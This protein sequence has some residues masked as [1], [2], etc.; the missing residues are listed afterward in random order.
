[1]WRLKSLNCSKSLNLDFLGYAVSVFFESSTSSRAA[2][3]NQVG[4]HLVSPARSYSE[5]PTS[6]KQTEGSL[7]VLLNQ[8]VDFSKTDTLVWA[9]EHKGLLI[10]R[11]WD[12]LFTCYMCIPSSGFST[13]SYC[14]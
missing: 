7:T 6:F 14:W 2:F 4:H 13:E 10:L 1:M 8:Y 5:N 12:D 11:I 9:V 3:Q